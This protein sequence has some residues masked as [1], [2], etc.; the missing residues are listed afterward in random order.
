M[1]HETLHRPVLMAR[2]FRPGTT[3]R[4]EACQELLPMREPVP[5]RNLCWVQPPDMFE[6]SSSV[7][8]DLPGASP[9]PPLPFISPASQERHIS[10]LCS[11]DGERHPDLSGTT[12]PAPASRPLRRRPPLSSRLV[13]RGPL[14]L[15]VSVEA[16][17][18]LLSAPSWSSLRVRPVR[19]DSPIVKEAQRHLGRGY[20]WGGTNLEGG[21]DCSGFAWSVYRR[22]R[23]PVPL[24]WFRA[25]L[26]PRIDPLRLE[27]HG[28]RWV[29]SPRPGDVA[30]FGRQH[31]GLYVGHVRGRALYVGANHGGRQRRG[32][33]DLMPVSSVGIRPVYYR[34]CPEGS[35]KWSS[36]SCPGTKRWPMALPSRAQMQSTP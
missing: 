21:V 4:P 25:P 18:R 2:P 22:L 33:V 10:K 12:T 13:R 6:P 17:P 20:R 15:G 14:L 31:V 9:E 23:I 1:L 28:M 19:T 26:D 11:S 27:R 34:W 29:R 32:R 35:P 36:A 5:G 16:D 8:P 30:V 7:P 3:A 24:A